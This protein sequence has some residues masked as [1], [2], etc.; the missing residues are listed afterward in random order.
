M[1]APQAGQIRAENA[2][3]QPRPNSYR[4][5]EVVFR[6]INDQHDWPDLDAASDLCGGIGVLIVVAFGTN[7]V[8]V[9]IICQEECPMAPTTKPTGI[10]PGAPITPSRQIQKDGDP[11]MQLPEWLKSELRRAFAAPDDLYRP[12]SA[13][14][15]I[16]R[17]R[18]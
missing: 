7:P 4:C 3:T 5:G 1:G 16:A 8:I 6:S 9:T 11:P 13:A 10:K 15:V 18:R 2:I 14:D 12:L 17:N